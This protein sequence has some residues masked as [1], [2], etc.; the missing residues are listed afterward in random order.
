VSDYIEI[1]RKNWDS[2]V[3]FHLTGYD[4]DKFRSDDSFISDVVRFDLPLLGDITDLDVVHLQCHIGTDTISLERLGARSVT[5]LDFSPKSLEAAQA[6]ASEV[7][8]NVRLV[9]SN[10]YDALDVLEAESFDL[11]YTGIGA[12]CWLNDINAWA[13]VVAGLLRQGGSLFI[14]EG[15]P[16]LNSLGDTLDDG[17]IPLHYPYF[18]TEGFAISEEKTYV[19]HE[20]SLASPESIQFSHGLG[21]IIAALQAAGLTFVSLTEHTSVPWNH[22]GD[23]MVMTGNGEYELRDNPKRLAAS[24]TLRARK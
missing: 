2:R 5:G 23:V 6:L 12:I 8:S 17:T 13:K 16:M 1:N 21:E 11:V 14:R 22:F 15:H 18:E 10:V 19:E 9:E 20:G 3:P 4:L 7:H 24:F